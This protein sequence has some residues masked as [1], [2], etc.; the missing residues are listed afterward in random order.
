MHRMDWGDLRFFH[1]IARAGSVRGA[2]VKMKVNHSTVL[3][4]I[5]T[6][7][8]KLGVRLF[9]RLPT[10]YVMTP[11]GEDMLVSAE[12]IDE[13]VAAL[14]R[15]V[16]GQD[17]Q[18]SGELRVTVPDALGSHLITPILA[19]FSRAYPGIELD[20]AVS[21]KAFNLTKREADVAVRI[22][23]KP[24]EHLIGRRLLRYAKSVYASVDYLA[25]HDL[26]KPSNCCWIGWEDSAPKPW[27]IK[28]SDFVDV[29][30]RHKINNEYVQLEAAKAGMGLTMLPCFMADREPAL[31]RVPPGRVLPSYEIWVL[32]HV[33][34]RHTVRVRTFMSFIA[35]GVERYRDLLEGKCPVV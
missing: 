17:A 22:T 19:D 14:D 1:A 9:D 10:G 20:L 3:R 34:L 29:P 33:D 15:R 2:A 13:E 8:E 23:S 27:W 5:T 30:L 25:T 6:F 31:R 7:E 18:L 16:F 26:S 21:I 12:R 24:P 35:D 4:R 11:A 32:T 28:E